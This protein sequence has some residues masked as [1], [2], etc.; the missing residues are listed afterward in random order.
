MKKPLKKLK[1]RQDEVIKLWE[2]N[3]DVFKEQKV[4][5]SIIVKLWDEPIISIEEQPKDEPERGLRMRK[6]KKI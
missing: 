3:I 4:L 6:K 1:S 2:T 5:E